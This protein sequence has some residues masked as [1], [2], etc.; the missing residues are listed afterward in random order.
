VA[1]WLLNSNGT[2]ASGVSVGAVPTAWSI[3]E[4]GD[5]N[6]DGKSDIL[7]RDTS[8]NVVVWLMNGGTVSSSLAVANVPTAWTIQGTNAD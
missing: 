5:F 1:M 6:G 7:W 8:G 3:V 2:V 4:T